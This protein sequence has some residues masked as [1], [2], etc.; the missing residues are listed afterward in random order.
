MVEAY[1]RKFQGDHLDDNLTWWLLITVIPSRLAVLTKKMMIVIGK[2]NLVGMILERNWEFI[3]RNIAI[4]LGYMG[5]NILWEAEHVLRS[6]FKF[7]NPDLFFPYSLLVFQFPK[8]LFSR[9]ILW[10][11]YY[12]GDIRGWPRI[13]SYPLESRYMLEIQLR[14]NY[15]SIPVR[16]KRFE[17][18]Q[19]LITWIFFPIFILRVKT[20]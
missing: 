5:S 3:V 19:N 20:N 1:I 17:K 12:E 14:I 16:S 7:Y 9:V 8:T 6:K 2:W 11:M 18:N 13:V 10:E 4:I 15:I